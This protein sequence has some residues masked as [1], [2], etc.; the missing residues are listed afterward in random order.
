MAV[1]RDVERFLARV[2][3]FDHVGRR[4]SINDAGGDE[5]IHSLVVGRF[6]R[7]MNE[8]C[9]TNRDRTT[10]KSHADGFLV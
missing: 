6:R 1:L 9:P 2:Q 4:W 3:E 8:T 7:V 5:L 10:Q